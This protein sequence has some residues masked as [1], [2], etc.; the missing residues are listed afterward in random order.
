M[1]NNRKWLSAIFAICFGV[2]IFVLDIVTKYIATANLAEGETAT[3]LPKFMNFT[4][5]FNNGAAWNSFAGE[6]ILLIVLTI[7]IIGLFL[8]YYVYRYIKSKIPMSKTLGIAVGL[9]AGGCFGNL[10]D[11]IGFGYVRDFLNF[12]FVKFPVFNI[13]DMA[14]TFGIAILIIYFIFIYPKEEK[15]LKEFKSSE[16]KEDK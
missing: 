9:I 1:K 16:N 8:A 13:A 12:E 15:K 5:V 3:F 11:R 10:Y 2:V 14:L 7:I 6:Q 4:L